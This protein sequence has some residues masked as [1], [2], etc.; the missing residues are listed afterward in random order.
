MILITNLAVFACCTDVPLHV[1]RRVCYDIARFLEWYRVSK[2]VEYTVTFLGSE[3]LEI[4]TKLSLEQS[5]ECL[6]VAN[7][8][9]KDLH[10]MR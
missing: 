2:P 3:M 8:E 10:V 9:V 4:N 6:E 5:I 7:S 1:P